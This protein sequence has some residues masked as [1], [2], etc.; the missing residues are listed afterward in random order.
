MIPGTELS[1]SS[2]PASQ[3]IQLIGAWDQQRLLWVLA[4]SPDEGYY[5]LGYW[6]GAGPLRT[7]GPARGGPVALT[8]QG[9]S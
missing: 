8:A 7:F 9:P 4:S 3:P 1:F 6:T 5:Q 2:L